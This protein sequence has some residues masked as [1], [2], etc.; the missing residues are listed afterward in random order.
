[1][2]RRFLS[3]RSPAANKNKNNIN[4][5]D[6]L[7]SPKR[8]PTR[9]DFEELLNNSFCRKFPK[10]PKAN[11]KLV[12]FDLNSLEITH[13]EVLFELQKYLPVEKITGIRFENTETIVSA[14]EENKTVKNRWIVTCSDIQARNKLVTKEIKIRG[15]SSKVRLYDLA[16][17]EDYKL[18]LRN[19]NQTDKL[20]SMM[21]SGSNLAAALASI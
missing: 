10:E 19:T 21:L 18:F 20:Q 12:C 2:S 7:S 5:T 6:S 17:M 11:P 15:Q 14:N 3:T 16:N 8:G 1:M 13:Q 9:S 4:D